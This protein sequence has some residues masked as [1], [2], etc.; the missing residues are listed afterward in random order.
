[1][2]ES[3]GEKKG[4]DYSDV[5]FARYQKNKN[6]SSTEYILIGKEIRVC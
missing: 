3:A 2:Y 5:S 6:C 1:M 4:N